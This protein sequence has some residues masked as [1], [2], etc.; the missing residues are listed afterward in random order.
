M[1]KKVRAK[2]ISSI[3]LII[4]ATCVI[5]TIYAVIAENNKTFLGYRLFIIKTGSMQGTLEIGD[6]IVTRTPDKKQ[7]RVGSIISFISSE[8]AIAGKVN[9]HR[10]VAIKGDQYYTKG[11][12]PGAL[13]DDMPVRYGDILGEVVWKSTTAG[14]VVTWFE[15]PLNMLLFLILPTFLVFYFENENRRKK[16]Y[17]LFHGNKK[18][19]SADEIDQEIFELFSTPKSD[20]ALL[21]ELQIILADNDG[22]PVNSG[23]QSVPGTAAKRKMLTE[24]TYSV[25]PKEAYLDILIHRDYTRHKDQ[26]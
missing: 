14:R 17:R 15:K 6:L 13:P 1:R 21:A 23:S 3:L 5:I 10:I 12:A 9:T 25:F 26:T 19:R 8:P 2:L 7:L 11:D 24:S 22:K 16:L 18:K 20:D 4:M